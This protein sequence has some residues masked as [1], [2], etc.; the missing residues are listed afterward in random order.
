M[1]Q[2]HE[3]RAFKK[4]FGDELNIHYEESP[5]AH[6]WEFWDDKIQKVLKWLPLEER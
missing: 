3:H 1:Y 4:Y 5:G 2:S 6:T